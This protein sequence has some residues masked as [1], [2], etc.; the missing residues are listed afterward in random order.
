MDKETIIEVLNGWNFWKA[1][2]EAGISR[3]GYL[4]RFSR[5]ARTEQVVAIT[6]V[7]RSGKSTLIKQ[8]IKKQIA[9]GEDRMSFLYVNFDEPKFA[10]LLSLEFLQ[11]IYDAYQE[12]VKPET[13]PYIFLDEVQNVP[14][15]ERFVR[16]L[17]EKKEAHV[18][19]SGSTAKLLGPELGTLLTGRWVESRTYPLDFGE[20]LQFNQIKVE[21]K[22][23]IL[24]Q[25]VKIKQLLRQYL[26]FGGFPLVALKKE[27]REEILRRYLD[28][29]VERDIMARH[30][31]RKQE[32]L[33]ALVKY[34]LTNFASHTSYRRIAKFLGLSLDS[35]ERFS[36][37]MKEA[38][39]MFF[40]P[41]FS[42]SL[43]EQEV[44]PKIAY[45]IDPGLINVAGFRS[46][47]NIGKL[48]ENA[49][50][51][52]LIKGGKE[53]YYYKNKGECDF[54]TKEGSKVTRAI[55]VSYQI[56]ENKER[57]QGGLL[58]AMDAFKLR[59]GLIIT[60][61]ME[62]EEIVRGRK[63]IYRPLWKWLLE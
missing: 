11:Q 18:F 37:Y 41:K 3:E 54:L 55:Q 39:F 1:D 23:D 6:G 49:V 61:D 57:E 2:R 40:V 24:S 28:D 44:N 38:C 46:S 62:G 12:I 4:D 58:E 53:L 45:C 26:E 42:Y 32:K 50:F 31:I 13:K 19:V 5:L 16:G 27:E 63:I 7:R 34:Y 15:W 59:E 33:R 10:G 47:D 60:D 21:G 29:I 22:L 14:E 17:H 25:K 30:K 56:K 20:F 9:M 35:V 51:L 48:Y 8:F 52:S 43:K 36:S